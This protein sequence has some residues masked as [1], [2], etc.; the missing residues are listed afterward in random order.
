[1]SFLNDFIIL[2]IFVVILSFFW[3]LFKN[4][5]SLTKSLSVSFIYTGIIILLGSRTIRLFDE[6]HIREWISN[7]YNYIATTAW[8][9]VIYPFITWG[10]SFTIGDAHSSKG[11]LFTYKSLTFIVIWLLCFLFLYLFFFIISK[12]FNTAEQVPEKKDD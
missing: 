4:K 8:G 10:D 1:M 2:V 3:W 11:I 12:I 5:K 9:L 7:F 6:C